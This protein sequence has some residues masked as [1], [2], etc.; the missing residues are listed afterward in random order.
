MSALRSVF[1]LLHRVLP[2]R[3]LSPVCALGTSPKRGS[4]LRGGG[5][6]SLTSA[7]PCGARAWSTPLAPLL[8]ELASDSETEGSPGL[9]DCQWGKEWT[10]LV[11]SFPVCSVFESGDPFPQ[12]AHWGLPLRGAALRGASLAPLKGELSPQV[13]EGF[14]VHA[15]GAPLGV[16][17][18]SVSLTAL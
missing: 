12:C 17:V 3:P 10:H 5:T 18:L 1:S 15:L 13:T 7:A 4:A 2:W 11:L 9:W 6:R 14:S 8:G 16:A